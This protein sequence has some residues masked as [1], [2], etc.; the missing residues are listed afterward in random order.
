V[1]L[2][3]D[4]LQAGISPN[5]NQ[6]ELPAHP[7]RHHVS[8]HVADRRRPQPPQAQIARHRAHLQRTSQIGHP[9]VPRDIADFDGTIRR[10]KDQASAFTGQL[11][12]LTAG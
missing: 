1:H 6:L 10:E 9:A 7:L 8:T 2:A 12:C 11:D 5:R 4:L 3:L